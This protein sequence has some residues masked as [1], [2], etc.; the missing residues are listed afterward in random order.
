MVF[1]IVRTAPLS[2]SI[3]NDIFGIFVPVVGNAVI[4]A[5]NIKRHFANAVANTVFS[6]Y[7]TLCVIRNLVIL[8]YRSPALAN[9]LCS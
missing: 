4:E 1:P 6:L 8:R 7:V 9:L 5:R 3:R 2:H